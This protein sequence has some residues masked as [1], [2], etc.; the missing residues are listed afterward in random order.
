MRLERGMNREAVRTLVAG[1]G[2]AVALLC[3]V[4]YAH[5]QKA[6]ERYIPIG[7]SPGLSGKYTSIGT[8]ADASA[9][10]QTMTIADSTGSR[11]MQISKQTRIWLDR[12]ALKQSNITG[13]FADL[14][15][16][17]RVEVKYLDPD[18][19]QKAEWIK[20]EITSR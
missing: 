17:R 2:M 5:A 13:T 12:T 7:R 18:R 4:P 14:Q 8:I 16:G 9:R 11:T 3:G 6:T 20:V 15:P 19:R 10:D 1:L